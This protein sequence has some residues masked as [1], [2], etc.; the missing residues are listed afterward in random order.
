M[1]NG[2]FSSLMFRLKIVARRSKS[3]AIFLLL[4]GM[5]DAMTVIQISFSMSG[6]WLFT[7]NYV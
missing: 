1:E 5:L 3:K 7:T 6:I 4:E 2:V